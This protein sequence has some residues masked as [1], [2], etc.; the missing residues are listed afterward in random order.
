M[1]RR[2]SDDG[3][4]H[5]TVGAKVLEACGRG[6]LIG[7]ASLLLGAVLGTSHLAS[8]GLWTLGAAAALGVGLHIGAAI[9]HNIGCRRDDAEADE[10]EQ[11]ADVLTLVTAM[12]VVLEPEAATPAE[13]RRA[14]VELVTGDAQQQQGHGR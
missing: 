3:E 8:V 2:Y 4:N 6:L 1:R 7:T 11:R 5:H 9:A 14:Y 12:P 13:R 10:P